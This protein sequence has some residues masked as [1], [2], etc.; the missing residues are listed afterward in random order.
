[1]TA[2]VIVAPVVPAPIAVLA[3][4]IGLTCRVGVLA[5]L[6]I[7]GAAIVACAGLG[8]SLMDG[9]ATVVAAAGILSRVKWNRRTLL[10]ETTEVHLVESN[11]AN[12]PPVSRTKSPCLYKYDFTTEHARA[13]INEPILYAVLPTRTR[14][15]RSTQTPVIHLSSVFTCPHR[16]GGSAGIC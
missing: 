11:N 15:G 5:T 7:M 8:I 4:F 16:P 13:S 3:T 9:L 6:L 2:L 12:L 14:H 1:M 10:G